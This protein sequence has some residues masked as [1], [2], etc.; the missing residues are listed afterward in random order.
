M[1]PIFLLFIESEIGF[2]IGKRNFT[3]FTLKTSE[4][5]HENRCGEV[6]GFKLGFLPN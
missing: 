2:S 6:P 1:R 4:K 5:P 3:I